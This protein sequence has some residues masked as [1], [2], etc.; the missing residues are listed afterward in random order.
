MEQ[1]KKTLTLKN[2][3]RA[4]G[5]QQAANLP[6]DP[7]VSKEALDFARDLA[8]SGARE[9]AINFVKSKLVDCPRDKIAYSFI[10]VTYGRMGE[11]AQVAG[12]EERAA[13]LW[14][15]SLD[16]SI[17]GLVIDPNDVKLLAQAA[18]TFRQL[19]EYDEAESFLLRALRIDDRDKLSWTAMG[20]YCMRRAR[21][22]EMLEDGDVAEY[23]QDAA[24]CFGKAAELDPQD[25]VIWRKLD[26]VREAG[27]EPDAEEGFDLGDAALDYIRGSSLVDLSPAPAAEPAAAPAR[28]ARTLDI[29]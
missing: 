13:E 12:D 11:N 6:R 14:Q 18:K 3:S 20:E 27:F 29:T 15:E 19:G 1:R 25:N 8:R 5:P 21:E 2:F 24:N 10:A 16:Y 22:D 26:E 9:E 28:R 4:A 17:S 23:M 7:W